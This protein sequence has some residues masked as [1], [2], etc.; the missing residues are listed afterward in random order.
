MAQWPIHLESFQDWERH[1]AA[2]LPRDVVG[3]CTTALENRLRANTPLNFFAAA[4]K[5]LRDMVHLA[6]ALDAQERATLEKYSDLLLAYVEAEFA[7]WPDALRRLH[8]ALEASQEIYRVFGTETV[9]QWLYDA[10]Y[11]DAYR[12]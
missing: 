9:R 1:L 2:L 5:R 12:L 3:L 11:Y 8:A 7:N 6:V 4:I 10:G